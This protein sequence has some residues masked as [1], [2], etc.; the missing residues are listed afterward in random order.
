M[1]PSDIPCIPVAVRAGILAFYPFDN[2][3][4]NDVSGNGH[5]LS[6]G[7]LAATSADRAGNPR[8]AFRFHNLTNPGERLLT[9]QTGFLDSLDQFSVSLWF[10]AEDSNR[11]GRIYEGLISRGTVTHPGSRSLSW[12]TGLS[13]CRR[14]TSGWM[15]NLWDTTTFQY[16]F[17]SSCQ[18]KVAENTGSWH[19]LVVTF[20]K[21]SGG[22]M[23]LFKD[24]VLHSSITGG[25]A[26]VV[27][28][29]G[30]LIL[31]EGYHGSLDDV[32][33]YDR[34]L[35]PTDVTTLHGLPACCISQ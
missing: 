17:S 29:V 10:K 13:D 30:N 35:S 16:N 19:H 2:G 34:I 11:S 26:G 25:T 20:E 1:T 6:N 7:T 18:H 5:N 14:A 3:S 22:A 27:T 23:S 9:T 32:I 12:S 21:S 8:C 15:Y 33:L 24:G 4:I 28:D 31:G